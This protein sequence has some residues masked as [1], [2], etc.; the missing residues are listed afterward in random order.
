MT[1]RGA[2]FIGPTIINLDFPAPE[3]DILPGVR[4]GRIEAFPSPAYWAY[5]I[6]ARRLEVNAVNYKL[7]RTLKEE[8]GACLLGGHGIPAAIGLAAFNKLKDCG[9]FDAQP[10]SEA[11]LYE[12]LSEPIKTGNKSVRYRFARQK[13]RYLSVALNRLDVEMPPT[14]SG[15]ALRDWL[16]FI[17][18][19]GHKTASWIARNWLCADDVAILDIHILRAGL[20]AGFFPGDLTVER[21]YLKL[22]QIFLEF[23]EAMGVKASE[24]DALIW[25]EMQ[26]SSSTVF[27][28]IEN[29]RGQPLA[30]LRPRSSRAKNRQSG[31]SQ[32][33]FQF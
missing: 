4:W 8:V 1:Q 15:R 11:T 31:T 24:L 13:S 23:S 22:E 30:K 27:S 14:D 20:L 10:P 6:L 29:M 5:Q 28:L 19:I 33:T 7:G 26:A 18:G 16:T 32:T 12:W 3:Q 21:D 17:P 2:V 9:A 25:Y